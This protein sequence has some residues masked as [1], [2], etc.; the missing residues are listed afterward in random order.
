[1]DSQLK[2][3]GVVIGNRAASA[4]LALR[5][6][7]GSEI[8]EPH[9]GTE[10]ITS[11]LPG[12]WR[13]DPVS[14]NPLALG[15]HWG[16]VKP[17]AMVSSHQFRAPAPPPMNSPEYTAAFDEAKRLGGDGIHTDTERTLEQ[18]R[19]GTFWAYDGTP[20]LCAPPRLY[21]QLAVH[22]ALQRGTNGINLA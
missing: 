1:P 12:H 5:A 22:I 19:I 14:Q 13:Q 3:N 15:A 20:S 7:D 9:V 11:D 18:T 2:S 17:F 8:P 16:E 6:G 4:I 10:F 21:N